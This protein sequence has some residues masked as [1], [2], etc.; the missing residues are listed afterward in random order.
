MSQLKAEE[1]DHNSGRQTDMDALILS[2]TAD[3]GQFDYSGVR[4]EM[5]K[6]TYNVLIPLVLNEIRINPVLARLVM[7][8]DI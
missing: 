7:T 1:F 5:V 6:N 2:D 4:N 3:I 8:S